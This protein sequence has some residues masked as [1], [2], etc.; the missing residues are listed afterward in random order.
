MVRILKDKSLKERL[1]EE[2]RKTV[3]KRF[4]MSRELEQM[5]DLTGAF[6]ACFT[7]NQ[8]RL[9]QLGLAALSESS[10]P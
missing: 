10:T 2:A 9:A 1:G 3:E 7:A 4:L 8:E 5:L 6:E